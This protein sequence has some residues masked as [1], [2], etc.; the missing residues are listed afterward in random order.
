M[1]DQTEDTR[2]VVQAML[3]AISAGD[4]GA[5]V[6]CLDP[7]LDFY[8]PGQTHIHGRFK[9]PGEFMRIAGMVLDQLA[10]P[11]TL[12]V[13]TTIVEGDAACVEA[14]GSSVTKKGEPYSNDYCF[15]YR[16]KNGR[17]TEMTEYHDTDLVRLVLLA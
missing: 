11:V 1:T 5:M 13:K 15:V 14:T 6:A 16:V 7:E 2:R 12:T 4:V 9:G 10:E 8:M 3:D 17:I